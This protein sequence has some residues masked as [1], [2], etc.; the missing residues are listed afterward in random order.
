MKKTVGIILTSMIAFSLTTNNAT[1]QCAD[2]SSAKKNI[3]ELAQENG[4]TSLAS[5][6]TKTDLVGVLQAEG[7]YTV[8]APTNEAFDN[9]LSA[10]G[11]SSIDDVPVAVLKEILLYHVVNAKVMSAQV[12][13][14]NVNTLQG[15][16]IMLSTSDGIKANGVSVVSPYDVDASNGVIHTVDQV[17]VPAS[18]AQFVNTVL[19]PAYFNKN[20]ST[21]IAAAVKAGVVE[22]LLNTP[23]LTIF[24]PNNDAF[25]AS[26]IN[27][28]AVDSKTLASVLTYHVVG[29]KLLSS[30]IPSEATTVNGSKLYFSLLS[31]GNFI[32]KNTEII[33]VDI[34]SG[35]GVVHVIN[36]VL[37]PI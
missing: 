30:G 2:D 29:A 18:I 23:N 21:L 37:M 9:L 22:T 1:A 12:S 17:L 28:D 26:G 3:V 4:F 24:A 5:A 13:A 10:I 19:E 27:L 36:N 34:E 25:M 14:G 33:A 20:F 6:L 15:S 8:F 32:N 7:S 35:S 31:S 16:A 11:Q